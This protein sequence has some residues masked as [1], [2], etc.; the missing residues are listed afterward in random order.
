VAVTNESLRSDGYP[1][2]PESALEAEVVTDLSRLHELEDDWRALAVLRENAFVTPEWFFAWHRQYGSE[3]DLDVVA[4]RGPDGTLRGVMP[5]TRDES[6]HPTALK[7]GG[8]NLA[9]HLHPVA[10]GGAEE[11]EVAAVAGRKLGAE[12]DRWNAI[13]LNNVDLDAG[14][15]RAM[16]S[17]AHVSL[18]SI[19]SRQTQMPYIRLPESWEAYLAGRSRNL[20]SQLKRKL[21]RLERGHEVRFRRTADVHELD[22]DLKTFFRLHD[23]RWDPR[24]GSSSKT[25]RAR[26]FHHDFS[27]AALKLGWLR[28]WF[29]EVDGEPVAAWYGWCL[30]SRYS[31]YL[32]GFSPRWSRASVGLLLLAHTVR[33]AIEEGAAEYDM[34]LGEERYKQRFANASRPVETVFLARA[35]HP[36]RVLASVEAALWRAYRRLPPGVRDRTRSLRATVRGWF[37]HSQDR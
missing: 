36:V 26:A 10:R 30:G 5:L 22:R 25:E 4:V 16:A 33:A 35:S 24:G 29:M 19:S 34:L 8:A 32:A 6:A 37:P 17:A 18:A 14:W 27:A 28:L 23:A 31:Y 11:V 20:R 3:R 13:V 2:P 9:D 7:V 1:A 15:P 12:I 21:R